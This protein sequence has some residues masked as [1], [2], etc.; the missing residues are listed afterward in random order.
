MTNEEV[1]KA[2]EDYIGSIQRQMRDQ[3]DFIA[4]VDSFRQN[5]TQD[6]RKSAQDTSNLIQ[7]VVTQAEKA[8]AAFLEKFTSTTREATAE[9]A[10]LTEASLSPLIFS[11]MR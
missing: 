6:L 7:W 11:S 2:L 9:A 10:V 3:R 4:F 8:T 1:A 5:V